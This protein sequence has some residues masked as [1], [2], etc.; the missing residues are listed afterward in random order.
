MSVDPIADLRKSVLLFSGHM[1]DAPDRKSPRFSPDKEA[2]AA[3]AIANT[4][5]NVGACQRP[6]CRA[7]RPKRT[8][9]RQFELQLGN[10]CRISVELFPRFLGSVVCATCATAW[11][12]TPATAPALSDDSFENFGQNTNRKR[13]QRMRLGNGFPEPGRM[14]FS[15]G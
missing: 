15:V 10:R 9:Y 8:G 5:A 6:C 13:N 1:I 12:T 11:L 2:V 14:G 4:I 7:A 3:T